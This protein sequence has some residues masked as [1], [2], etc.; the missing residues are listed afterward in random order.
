MSNRIDRRPA[1]PNL[2]TA[3]VRLSNRCYHYPTTINSNK[4]RPILSAMKRWPAASESPTSEDVLASTHGIRYVVRHMGNGV[5]RLLSCGLD[6]IEALKEEARTGGRYHLPFP[7]PSWLR[8]VG[9]AALESI[10]I[11]PSEMDR[12]RIVVDAYVR[13]IDDETIEVIGWRLGVR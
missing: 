3:A 9:V 13:P 1:T 5:Y 6:P 2:V 7:P 10:G 12:N 4:R 8:D 11:K